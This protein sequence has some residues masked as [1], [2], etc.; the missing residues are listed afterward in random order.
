VAD[1][2]VNADAPILATD[3]TLLLAQ[4][5]N[6]QWLRVASGGAIPPDAKLILP[7]TFRAQVK[8][9]DGLNITL[10]G[11]IQLTHT[12]DEAGVILEV[13]GGKM[14][15]RTSTPDVPARLLLSGQ[16]LT[17][18]LSTPQTVLAID[19]THARA[20]GADPLDESS[21]ARR[22]NVLVIQGAAELA[23]SGKTAKLETGQQWLLIEGSEP[24]QLAVKEIPDWIDEPDPAE[25]SLASLARSGLLGL[26]S[27]QQ[28]VEL[29]L[30]EAVSFRRAEVG[31]LAAE[32]LLTMGRADVYFGGD[33]VLN[34]AKQK[35]YW[36][37]HLVALLKQIDQSVESAEQIRSAVGQMESADGDQLFEL[38][39][40][41]SQDQLKAGADAKLVS[42]LDA[43]TMAMR[44][45]A[46]HNLKQI[47]GTTLNYRADQDN[48]IR[49]AAEQK[50]WEIRVRKEDIRWP[51][52]APET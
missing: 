52:T 2:A 10:V 49:R 12:R 18:K 11:S 45:L 15:V 43:P 16:S 38:L 34:N 25:T 17:A 4:T 39:V 23:S 51:E 33:G 42:L 40:G 21:H 46:L 31:A 32:A 44:V 13:A 6:G 8:S 37:E 1:G 50:K 26:I 7:P 48:P 3:N 27:E 41:Y 36:D 29:S 30:R 20:P 22:V 9:L 19:L 14:L 28:P 35:A 24:T 47:T 5:P